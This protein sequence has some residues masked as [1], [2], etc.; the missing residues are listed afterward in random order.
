MKLPRKGGESVKNKVQAAMKYRPVRFALDMLDVY[1]GKRVS[2][3]S[4]ELAYFLIL[5]FF[6]ILLCVSVFLGR[7]DLDLSELLAGADRILPG[8]VNAILTEYLRYVEASQS[9]ALFFAGVMMTVLPASAAVRGLILT[10]SHQD[11]IGPLYPAVL[12]TL[13]RGACE[14]MFPKE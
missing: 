9:P 2:R 4:A 8:G 12:E 13:A 1:F 7:L 11:Q 5:T 14:E 6:P 3:A 10:V